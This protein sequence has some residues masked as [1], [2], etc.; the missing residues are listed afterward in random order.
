MQAPRC[1][2]GRSRVFGWPPLSALGLQQRAMA[3]PIEDY[4]IVADLQSVALV[5]K[6]GSI[7]WLCLPRFDSDA[8]FAALLGSRDNGRFRIAPEG[9]VTAVRRAYRPGTLV[10]ETELE[11]AEGAVTLIDLMPIS[12][13][14][15]DLV[16]I[17]AGKR[18]SV[19][20]KM[21][22]VIRFA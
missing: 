20:M 6:D 5:G 15:T 11:T 18:G 7:D 10:L 19:K 17:V 3:L 22:L 1:R 13:N 21:D 8:C 4:A 16:R 12:G 9:E 2:L 14:G